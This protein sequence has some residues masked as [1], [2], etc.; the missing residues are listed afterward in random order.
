MK[1]PIRISGSVHVHNHERLLCFTLHAR[2]QAIII[3]S[4]ILFLAEAQI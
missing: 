4:F 1:F 2:D 3:L